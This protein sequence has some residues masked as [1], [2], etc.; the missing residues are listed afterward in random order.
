MDSWAVISNFWRGRERKIE[1]ER[2]IPAVKKAVGLSQVGRSIF[3]T[4]FRARGLESRDFA[5][6]GA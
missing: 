5:E 3:R 1:L 2:E 4:S 6:G